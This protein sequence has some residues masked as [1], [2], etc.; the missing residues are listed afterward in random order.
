MYNFPIF[1]E[2]KNAS[3]EVEAL[4]DAN[5]TEA[6]GFWLA[7]HFAYNMCFWN[8]VVEGDSVNVVKALKSHSD[9]KSYFSLMI[10]D[11]KSLSCLFSSFL[12]SH[13]QRVD[14][15]VANLL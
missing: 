10:T 12:V 6:L 13:V 2:E 3:G 5:I 14:N 8:I 15:V 11:C 1:Y 4:P 9:G 7:I